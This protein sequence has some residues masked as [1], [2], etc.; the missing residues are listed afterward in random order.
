MRNSGEKFLES[1][2]TGNKII[3]VGLLRWAQFE[4]EKRNQPCESQINGCKEEIQ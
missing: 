2:M 3:E 1:C 4:K